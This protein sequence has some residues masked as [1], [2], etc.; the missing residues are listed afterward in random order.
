MPDLRHVPR[1]ELF[2][3]LKSDDLVRYF[4]ELRDAASRAQPSGTNLDALDNLVLSADKLMYATGPGALALTTF[5][6]FA[7]TLLDDTNAPTMRLTLGL[8]S[9][10]TQDASNV[11][12]TGGAVSGGTIGLASGSIGYATGNGG[13]ATQSTSK[14]TAV[15]LN[16]MS[17]DITLNAA[18]LAAGATV[19]FTLNNSN[20]AATDMVMATHNSAGTNG[21]YA[22]LAQVPAGGQSLISVT[23]RSSGSLSEAIV[24]RFIVFKAATS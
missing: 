12:I 24:L 2:R 6:A 23:N 1:S 22:V 14:A 13:T 9:M 5:T 20:I 10:A 21:A 17:G 8:G 15:T 4:E 19:S 11:A 18:A 3:V 16:K 7:R